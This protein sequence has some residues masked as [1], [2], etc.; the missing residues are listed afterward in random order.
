MMTD[1]INIEARKE[2]V[3]ISQNMPLKRHNLIR[4]HANICHTIFLILSGSKY[5]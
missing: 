2:N 3:L 1:V 5:Y 4:D